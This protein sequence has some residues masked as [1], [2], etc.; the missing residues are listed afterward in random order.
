M[1]RRTF[2]RAGRAT[3][4]S[5]IFLVRALRQSQ[6]RPERPAG[7]PAGLKPKRLSGNTARCAAIGTELIYT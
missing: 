7:L 6:S 5:A 4:T 2:L 3:S 1:S